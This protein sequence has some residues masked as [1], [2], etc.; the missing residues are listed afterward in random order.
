M[1]LGTR[2]IY[3]KKN[4]FFRHLSLASYL[5]SIVILH[6]AATEKMIIFNQYYYV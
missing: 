5:K 3:S 2:V 4:E 6:Q 1:D